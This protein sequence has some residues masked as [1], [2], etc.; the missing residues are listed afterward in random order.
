VRDQLV[1][2]HRD[3]QDTIAQIARTAV[4][5]GHFSPDVDPGQIATDLYGI[6]LAFYL[7]CHLLD[8]STAERRARLAFERLV[9]DAAT[10]N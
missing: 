6:M 7:E 8:D 1:Q 9:R 4:A 3:L 10:P 2:A 5:E